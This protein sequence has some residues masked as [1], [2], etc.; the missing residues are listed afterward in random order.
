MISGLE[1]SPDSST[2]IVT[3]AEGYV[4]LWS[5]EKGTLSFKNWQ[6][7]P[8]GLLSVAAHPGGT[9]FAVG[10]GNGSVQLWRLDDLAQ[11]AQIMR[12][13]QGGVTALAYTPDGRT[14]I[15][16][17]ED[18]LIRLHRTL[19]GLIEQGCAEARRNLTRAE[20]QQYL[21]DNDYMAV[22]P[23]FSLEK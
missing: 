15:S 14:L 18:H 16:G 17:A 22:C 23:Q 9:Y 12:T 4:E 10:T 1:V 8:G 2:V 13:H 11:P 5:L 19:P 21:P 20:W 3:G 7:V 6:G